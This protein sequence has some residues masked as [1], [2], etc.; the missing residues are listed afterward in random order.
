MKKNLSRINCSPAKRG[1]SQEAKLVADVELEL[2]DYTV[3]QWIGAISLRRDGLKPIEAAAMTYWSMLRANLDR[4][5]SIPPSLTITDKTVDRLRNAAMKYVLGDPVAKGS[6]PLNSIFAVVRRVAANQHKFDL[7][8]AGAFS[9][10]YCLWVL[11]APRMS[12]RST[13][14]F[15]F[16][17]AFSQMYGTTPL[18]WLQVALVIL[19]SSVKPQ[20]LNREYFNIA[21]RQGLKL[22]TDEVVLCALETLAATPQQFRARASSGKQADRAF[23]AY[24][25]NPLI[26]YPIARPWSKGLEDPLLDRLAVP[27]PGVLA[28]RVTSRVREDMF[29]HFKSAFVDWFGDVFSE[30]VGEL[31]LNCRDNLKVLSEKQIGTFVGGSPKRPDWLMISPACTI[32]FECKAARLDASVETT[33]VIKPDSTVARHLVKAGKQFHEFEI[34]CD[35]NLPSDHIVRN[36][37]KRWHIVVTWEELYVGKSELRD[38]I[39][40]PSDR[41]TFAFN[42]DRFEALIALWSLGEDPAYLMEQIELAGYDAAVS[43]ACDRTGLTHRRTYQHRYDKM[44]Y[45]SMGL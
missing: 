13:S 3:S 21:R 30:Y 9:R 28:Y 39:G 26:L 25:R 44:L 41:T 16:E 1:G 43:A 5:P 6:E 18:H 27:A 35:A 12:R 45:E 14:G 40:R 29:R 8:A 42:I 33:G 2:R 7:D 17:D 15:D 36:S 20:L 19:C 11:I 4:T 24:D 37:T 23:F 32:A 10:A 22:P 31:L 34:Y 38:L